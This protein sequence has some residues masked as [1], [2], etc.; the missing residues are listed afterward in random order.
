MRR[1]AQGDRRVDE[2]AGALLDPAPPVWPPAALDAV[3]PGYCRPRVWID[4]RRSRRAVERPRRSGRID[5]RLEMAS[6]R[7]HERRI[8]A[9]QPRG[10]IA[11]APRRDVI[12]DP[13][14]DVRA[15]VDRGEV[16]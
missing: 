4:G 9:E 12:G 13:A 3:V 2:L 15:H 6:I 7:E 10:C 8:T 14:D 5:E 1:R 11:G 16:D